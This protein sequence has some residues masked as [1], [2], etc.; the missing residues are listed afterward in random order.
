MSIQKRII[1]TIK[2]LVAGICGFLLCG[3]LG[4]FLG[5]ALLRDLVIYD[6]LSGEL[7]GLMTFVLALL[8]AISG[9][10]YL[11]VKVKV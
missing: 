3:F 10:I 7:G 8:C 6:N 1:N 4:L 5:G 2:R 11:A 9:S